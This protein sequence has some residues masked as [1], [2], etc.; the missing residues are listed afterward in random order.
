[1]VLPVLSKV[2]ISLGGS[3]S[4]GPGALSQPSVT[5]ESSFDPHMQDIFPSGFSCRVFFLSC[6]LL[7]VQKQMPRKR[8]QIPDD[9]PCGSETKK[10]K[11][12]MVV[13]TDR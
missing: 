2:L 5:R 3:F 8:Y 4:F 6:H 12:Q 9:F 13:G 7:Q 11:Y 1:M 10:I